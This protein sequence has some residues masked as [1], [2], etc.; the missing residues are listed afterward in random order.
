MKRLSFFVALIFILSYSLT[1][2]AFECDVTYDASKFEIKLKGVSQ[3][4]FSVTVVPTEST[5]Y[6]SVSQGDVT[7]VFQY[8][9]RTEKSFDE[10]ILLDSSLP[11]GEYTIRI[12]A[13]EKYIEPVIDE[14]RLYGNVFDNI[15]EIEEVIYLINTDDGE[16][17]L[18]SLNSSDT[19]AKLYETVS[20][21]ETESSQVAYS[22][23]LSV[24]AEE[25]EIYGSYVTKQI[26][27][28]KD[29][30]DFESI[31]EFKKLFDEYKVLYN[32]T[33]WEDGALDALKILEENK[34]VFDVDVD[35][36]V[37][38]LGNLSKEKL[39]S[40]IKN[41]EAD[42]K[43]FSKELPFL[44][45]LASVQASDR[46]QAIKKVVTDTYSDVLN[47]DY[48][49]VKNLDKVFQKMMSFSY[50]TPEDIETN[51][52]KADS[53]V[54]K[55]SD[56][57]QSSGGGGGG[58]GDTFTDKG[59]EVAPS[60]NEQREEKVQAFSDVSPDFWA[61]DA[62]DELSK[63]NI[64]TGYPNK[65]FLPG[66]DVTRAEFVKMLVTAFEISGESDIRFEDVGSLD[67]HCSFIKKAYGARL[68]TGIDD[69]TFL[70]NGKITREDACVIVYRYLSGLGKLSEDT[71]TFSD[72]SDFSDYSKDAIKILAGN[73]IINGMG[74]NSFLPKSNINRASCAFLILSCMKV[75]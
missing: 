16:E 29:G 56:K 45:A 55:K 7:S 43:A 13:N 62:I 10:K 63:K 42:G 2:F 27:G 41:F 8:D 33:V 47:I 31:T 65:T 69:K 17:L 3:S 50:S 19:P 24:N 25:F 5:E 52:K 64:I 6:E 68:I 74:E 51:F 40:L 21:G 26:M 35:R 70:P 66:E 53:Q 32:V 60:R 39:F 57:E 9:F 20:E 28:T 44:S 37:S 75:A 58:G 4:P 48:D 49:D 36:F 67:W 22:E 15:S 54:N 12:R 18:L 1:V 34:K 72:E 38:S 73:G 46:W 23:L 61:Y 71:K 30:K 59:F 11:S 14:N